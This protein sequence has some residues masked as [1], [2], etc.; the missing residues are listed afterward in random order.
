MESTDP[1]E[2]LSDLLRKKP[3]LLTRYGDAI[4]GQLRCFDRVIVH[5][6]LVD[7]CTPGAL[8]NYLLRSGRRPA[9]LEAFA[10]PLN[11]QIRDNAILLAREHGVK[12]EY[13]QRK[14]FRFED[15]VAAILKER[16]THPG[17]VHIFSAKERATVFETR[18]SKQTGHVTLV[19]RSGCCV[20]YYFYLIHEQLGLVYVRVPTWL[21]FRVQIYL[22]GHELLARQLDRQNIAYE[23]ID[24]AFIHIASW[25]RAQA[26]ADSFEPKQLHRWLDELARTYCPP[27]EQF[28][29]CYHWSFMQAEYAWDV[30]FKDPAT[31]ANLFETLSREAIHTVR[32]EDVGRFLGKRLPHGHDTRV[33]SDLGRRVDSFRLRHHMGPTGLKFYT[34]HHRIFRLECTT[35][36]VSFFQHYREV[37]HNN[38]T[39]EMKVAAMKKSIYSLEALRVVMLAA[40][41]RYLEWLG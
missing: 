23:K 38:G 9:D 22:N 28:P 33:D 17:L 15:R 3:E 16:G 7:V 10:L 14:N 25:A 36:D 1:T 24:N 32:A 40:L 39:K 35:N 12:I 18:K 2:P 26:L 21:P 11:N 34:K 5:G 13:V 6:L 4:E 8:A 37:V 29:R 19:Q 20:H 41:R 27:L 30:V 31:M